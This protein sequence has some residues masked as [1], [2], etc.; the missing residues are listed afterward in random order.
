MWLGLAVCLG[1]LPVLGASAGAGGAGGVLAAQDPGRTLV[2]ENFH[3]DIEVLESGTIRVVEELRVRFVGSWNGVYRR[4]PVSYDTPSGFSY[5]LRLGFQ[6]ATDDTG[7]SLRTEESRSGGYRQVKIW[8]PGAE[9]ATRTVR[10][11][12]TVPNGLRFFEEHDELYWNVTGTEWDYPILAA[13]ALVTLPGSTTDRRANAFTGAY[14]SEATDA[15]ATETDQGFLFETSE[16]LGLREGLTL[17][18]AWAPGVVHRPGPVEKAWLFFRSN[19]YFGMPLAAFFGMFFAW[20]R[21][22]K[23]PERRPISPAY[24]A[25]AGFRPA[26]VGTLVDDTV[27]MRD[28]TASIV[29]L[30]VRGFLRIEEIA[31]SALFG[32]IDET[33]YRFVLLRSLG[34]DGNELHR[35]EQRLLLGMFDSGAD[36]GSSV[37]MSDLENRF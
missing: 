16:P 25:P 6:G 19:F 20:R 35:Y 17:A 10:L 30:A 29:D 32:L 31:E 9:D 8:V 7:A 21:W 11:R 1:F 2:L 14:G 24:E 34:G 33:D 28:I 12:Y 22:G 26:E 3:A 36:P 4:I 15:R 5:A 23:D 37:L 27:D 13:S 18:V